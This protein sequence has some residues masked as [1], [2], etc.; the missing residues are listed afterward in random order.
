[1]SAA[2]DFGLA[3]A[4]HQLVQAL[5]PLQLKA[6]RNDEVLPALRVGVK[7]TGLH[8]PLTRHSGRMHSLL[9]LALL[10]LRRYDEAEPQFRAAAGAEEAAGH[11]RGHASAVESLALMRLRQWRFAEA[12]EGFEHAE[13]ILDTIAPDA[14][15]ASDV[16]R[17]RL[18]LHRHRGRALSGMGRHDEARERLLL[19]LDGFR[20]T[21]RDPYNAARTLCDL[22]A[23]DLA[24]GDPRAALARA[25]QAAP[26]LEADRADLHLR[27]LGVLRARCVSALERRERD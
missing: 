13:R 20:T 21:V 25:D 10:E 9:G 8:D 11:P 22:A 7:A 24:A 16:P 27:E 19:A 1:V 18:L 3:D 14:E 17:A 6:G 26:L 23:N 12:Y 15:G 2:A 4:V 5:W